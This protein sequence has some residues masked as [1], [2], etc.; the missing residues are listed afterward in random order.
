MRLDHDLDGGSGHRARLGLIVL[1]VDETVEAEC[2]RLLDVHGVILHCSR[3]R[4]GEAATAASL[5]AIAE[6]L[7]KAASL[8]PPAVQFDAIG[9]ACTSAAA[10]IGPGRVHALVREG[11]PGRAGTARA[12]ARS[13]NR[14]RPP[15]PPA[16]RSACGGSP[17]SALR[18]RR[19]RGHPF[20]VQTARARDR[21]LRLV[22][23]GRGATGGT[24]RLGVGAR[25]DHPRRVGQ[26][27]R[28]RVRLLHEPAHA[29]RHPG[30]R[31]TTRCARSREQPGTRW[32]LLRRAGI[33][34][35]RPGAGRLFKRA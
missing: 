30:R 6:R 11:R 9:Y 13:P 28:P 14:C 10:L 2:R 27:L 26:R 22:R 32:H 29:R 31:G 5:A 34:D 35:L 17:S 25:R 19:I 1:H 7:P 18:G 21:R 12:T 23:G 3:V 20:H 8:L 24:H 33:N 15:L 4:S 16:M